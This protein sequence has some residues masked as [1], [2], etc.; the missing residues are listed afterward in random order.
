MRKVISVA[1]SI[2]LCATLC[3]CGGATGSGSSNASAAGSGSQGGNAAT[4]S[5]VPNANSSQAANADIYMTF[6][7][8]P[9][10]DYT[11][12]AGK[13]TDA[14]SWFPFGSEGGLGCWS[15]HFY[16]YSANGDL[17]S[18]SIDIVPDL[19]TAKGTDSIT[20]T[21]STS[22]IDY[23]ISFTRAGTAEV[24]ATE[25]R[26]GLTI[27]DTFYVKNS[28]GSGAASSSQAPS[29][30][31]AFA[32]YE[33]VAFTQTG[34]GYDGTSVEVSLSGNETIFRLHYVFSPDK[35]EF[36]DEIRVN[37]SDIKDTGSTLEITKA[38]SKA[39]VKYQMTFARESI[40]ITAME[41]TGKT[42]DGKD[43]NI[44]TKV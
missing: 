38:A 40:R 5:Q 27:S 16:I 3:A 21:G 23:E 14:R 42:P 18:D 6:A 30:E 9:A 44:S 39:G 19:V 4:N 15:T 29:T 17:I 25:K 13:N 26:T 32:S 37:N 24:T 8:I 10:G 20:V 41:I 35:V 36:D 2:V 12:R 28:G 34:H 7:D 31:S 43:I 22:S 1:L 33:G 11:G